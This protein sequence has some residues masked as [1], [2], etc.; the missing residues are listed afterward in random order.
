MFIRVLIIAFLAGYLLWVINNKILGKKLKFIRVIT[1]A[2]VV[3]IMVYL[4][5]AGLSYTLD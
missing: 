2:L 5:L 3:T 4:L 1:G